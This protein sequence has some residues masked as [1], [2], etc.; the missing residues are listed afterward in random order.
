M[1]ISK[2]FVLGTLIGLCSF[3]SLASG[4]A[5]HIPGVFVGATRID[6]ETDFTFGIE[7]EYKFNQNWGAGAVYERTN[8]A[9]HGDG[10]GVW[11]VSAFYHP[12][13]NVRLG[14]G[15]GKERVGGGHPHTE[16]LVRASAS[17]DFHVGDFGVAPTIAVDFVDN[18]EALVFGVA[19]TKPF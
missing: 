12:V 17:Y 4:D 6:S 9:H 16:N 11:V 10:V 18:D 5:K 15:A 3:P 14:L 13:T 2:Y 7:Y 19:I 1:K 8:D